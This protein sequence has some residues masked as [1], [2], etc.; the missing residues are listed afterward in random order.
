MPWLIEVVEADGVEGP[1]QDRD[2]IVARASVGVD[3]RRL[4]R[5]T[6][7][8]VERPGAG[9]GDGCPLTWRPT[10]SVTSLRSRRP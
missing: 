1:G 5:F 2:G 10:G 4:L 9:T 3:R 7:M 8:V 6:L